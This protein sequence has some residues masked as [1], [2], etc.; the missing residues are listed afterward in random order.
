MP[1]KS[2]DDVRDFL[3]LMDEIMVE[4][5]LDWSGSVAETLLV[6]AAKEI[7]LVLPS[8]RRRGS[9]RRHQGPLSGP[10]GQLPRT[11]VRSLQEANSWTPTFGS[12]TGPGVPETGLQRP[13]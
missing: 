13:R 1:R 2:K 9:R 6:R 4:H 5:P 12:L 8:E 7:G 10:R 11:K 3:L